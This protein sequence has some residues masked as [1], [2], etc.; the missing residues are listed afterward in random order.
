MSHDSGFTSFGNSG[1]V[2]SYNHIKL[3]SPERFNVTSLGKFDF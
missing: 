1:A 2:V 3:F